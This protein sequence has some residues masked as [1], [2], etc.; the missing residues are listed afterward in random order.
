MHRPSPLQPSLSIA[1]MVKVLFLFQSVERC[2]DLPSCDASCLNELVEGPVLER[3]NTLA[4]HDTGRD[5]SPGIDTERYAGAIG[6][7]LLLAR[8]VH[9]PLGI[10]RQQSD[11]NRDLA[12]L[13]PPV[14]VRIVRQLDVAGPG[15]ARFICFNHFEVRHLRVA[16]GLPHGDA[17]G[18]Q[19]VAVVVE[20]DAVDAD[21][22][23]RVALHQAQIVLEVQAPLR[24][25]V[26]SQVNHLDVT[27]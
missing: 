23:H 26:R 19:Q 22:P 25:S 27:C 5:R 7:G 2:Q 8:R 14:C 20:D 15:R 10:Y 1:E 11:K 17:Q 24:A 3:G 16:D 13:E 6:P 21:H 12:A 18:V 9:D 4:M